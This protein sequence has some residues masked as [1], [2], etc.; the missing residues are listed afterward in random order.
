MTFHMWLRRITFGCSFTDI[1]TSWSPKIVQS[2]QFTTLCFEKEG[3]SSH[4]MLHRT[5]SNYRH[6]GALQDSPSGGIFLAA[7]G[8]HSL[9]LVI[10]SP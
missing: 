9:D 2:F 1:L 8:A 5:H 6:E 4:M 3:D 10:P 7:G